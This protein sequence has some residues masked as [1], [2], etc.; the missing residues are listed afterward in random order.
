VHIA[1][2]FRTLNAMVKKFRRN[3]F[4]IFQ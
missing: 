2:G 4:V 3:I 1:N